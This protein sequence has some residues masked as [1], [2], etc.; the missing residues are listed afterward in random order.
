MRSGEDCFLF[1]AGEISWYSSD[2]HPIVDFSDIF[3]E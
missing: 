3:R 2:V 1:C